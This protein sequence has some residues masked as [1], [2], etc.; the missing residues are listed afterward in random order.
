M[1]DDNIVM[2]ILRMREGETMPMPA[3]FNHCCVA[4]AS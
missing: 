4:Q 1:K 3:A 2:N